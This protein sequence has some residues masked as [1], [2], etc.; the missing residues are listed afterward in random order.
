MFLTKKGLRK[1]LIMAV[2]YF[3][4]GSACILSAIAFADIGVDAEM[5]V[6]GAIVYVLDIILVFWGR[7]A[8]G[9]G[10]LINLGNKLVRKELRP[11]EFIR[12]YDFLRNSDDLVIKKP[13]PEVLLFLAVAYD[14]LDDRENCLAAVD[15]MI[16]V[17]SEKK[18]TWALLMKASVLFSYDKKEEAEQLFIEAQRFRLD[19]MSK[20]LRDN[21]MKSDR[22]MAMG[23][24]KTAEAYN[25]E[26]LERSFPKV[27]NLTKL[28]A[29]YTLGKV[30]EN[31]HDDEKAVSYYSYCAELG[32]ETAIKASSKA[33]I[34]R[35]K[36]AG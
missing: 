18:R 10:K 13:S 9:K 4:L 16:A 5:L 34:E 27:D 24:Y 23:D 8:E 31:L 35:L 1:I 12:E 30:Y 36:Q 26:L 11:A 28:I 22:A 17:A 32:G 29:H 3:V 15:E 25:L 7:Y 19:L 33:A 14:S 21:I 6:L 2:C 20:T